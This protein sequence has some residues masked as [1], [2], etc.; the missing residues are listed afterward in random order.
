[1][2]A[3]VATFRLDAMSSHIAVTSSDAGGRSTDLEQLKAGAVLLT[4][5]GNRVAALALLWAAVAI[6]PVDRTVHRRLAA[7]LATAGDLDGAA[8]EYARYVEFLL[9]RGDIEGA[10]AELHYAA[11][12]LGR[13]RAIT[14]A[15]VTV[16]AELPALLETARQ[17]NGPGP[18]PITEARAPIDVVTTI[19]HSP[20][21]QLPVAHAARITLYSCLHDDGEG[22][23][24]QLEGGTIDVLPEKVRLLHGARVLET[25]SCIPTRGRKSHARVDGTSKVWVPLGAPDELLNAIDHHAPHDYTIEALVDGEWLDVDLVDTGC[26]FGIRP[27]ETRTA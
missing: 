20:V 4:Q 21:V 27:R 15:A 10:T 6:D 18:Q 8:Q 19:A 1:M 7:T 9:P 26:R 25:R 14:D 5:H 17:R 24:L 23:W 13:M 12:T 16:A 11:T 22:E 2:R 3:I